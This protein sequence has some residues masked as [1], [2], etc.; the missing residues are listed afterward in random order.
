M[1]DKDEHSKVL[2]MVN[3]IIDYLLKNKTP[4]KIDKYNDY[5]TW[6]IAVFTFTYNKN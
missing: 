4:D 5:K 1:M 2:I 6:L 3:R